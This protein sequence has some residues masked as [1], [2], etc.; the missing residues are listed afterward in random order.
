M[1][2]I[3]KY[4]IILSFL[5]FNIVYNCCIIFHLSFCYILFLVVIY[6]FFRFQFYLYS[7]LFLLV[8]SLFT[9]TFRKCLFTFS[10]LLYFPY[11][12]LASTYIFGGFILWGLL[13][14]FFP[15]LLMMERRLYS[16]R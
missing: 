9:L 3:K 11:F 7:L 15:I 4:F 12:F 1:Y 2:Y 10:F 5:I 16:N 6:I 8:F 14:G 13:I